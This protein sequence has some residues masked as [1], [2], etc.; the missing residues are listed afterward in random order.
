MEP[1]FFKTPEKFRQ[2]LD[3]HHNI[4]DELWVGYYKKA[5]GKGSITWPESVDEAICYGWI[6]GI[7]KTHDDESYKIRFTPRRPT[8]IWSAVN[9]DK[10]EQLIKTKRMQPS[11][12]AAYKNKKDHKSMIYSFEQKKEDIKLPGEY[13]KIFRQNKQAWK[14]F[15][16][17]APYYRRAA[18]W[19]VISAKREETKQRR[20]QTL[21][22]DSENQI[23]IKELRR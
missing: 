4:K 13:E 19:W 21:I 10:A 20:L 7:R 11:G 2:W 6:D 17:Q 8:S 5:T 23:K 9:I 16:D 14:F 12:L 18:T 3:K 22:Q 1:K 15:S